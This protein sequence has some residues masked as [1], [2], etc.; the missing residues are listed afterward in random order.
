MSKKTAIIV[1][2]VAVVLLIGALAVFYFFFYQRGAVDPETPGTFPPAGGVVPPSGGVDRP[3]ILPD[4][5]APRLLQL[6]NEPI[7][8][9][10][11]GI[12]GGKSVVRYIDKGLGRVYQKTFSEEPATRITNTTIAK[13][14]NV[15]WQQNGSGAVL[16]YLKEDG[17]SIETL[18]GT[19]KGAGTESV[20]ELHASFLPS[21]VVE[22]A[23]SPDGKN[24]L[25]LREENGGGAV[26]STLLGT[27]EKRE[28]FRSSAREWI[29]LWPKKDMALLL[30]KPSIA[31]FGFVLGLDP[32]TGSSEL[33]L[34]GK[35]GLTVS[36]GNGTKLLYSESVG[37]ALKVR[38]FDS[39]NREDSLFPLTTLPEKCVWSTENL[40]ILY[41]AVP[42]TLPKVAYPDAWY[43]GILSFKDGLWKVDLQSGNIKFISDISAEAGQEIDIIQPRL[44]TD[45]KYLIF[46]NKNDGTLWS[47]RL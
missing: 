39:V 32:N 9:A 38:I 26:Y 11:T 4:T 18:F 19:I 42:A 46:V 47:Y 8:G 27:S 45:E 44:S 15:A 29:L 36:T 30:T 35:R 23:I 6:T 5:E 13:V 21:G 22:M 1:I 3:T 41:C 40:D 7:A 43:Q 33:L 20:G 28:V 12:G 24:L 31:A 37:S 10:I 25:Y 34:S 2:S 14:Y 16:Q 17:E